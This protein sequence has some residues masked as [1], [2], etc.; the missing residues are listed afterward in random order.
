VV[1]RI[2]EQFAK[3]Y[4]ACVEESSHQITGELTSPRLQES[5]VLKSP[6]LRT[7]PLFESTFLHAISPKSPRF[8]YMTFSSATTSDTYSITSSRM[9]SS[10]FQAASTEQL[11]WMGLPSEVRT[12]TFLFL[13][14]VRLVLKIRLE[15]H[16]SG[17]KI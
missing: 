13:Y 4:I 17:Y 3:R 16:Q 2:L 11:V 1:D 12:S 15:W 7:A 6:S 8:D 9:G 14:L 5:H 10:E